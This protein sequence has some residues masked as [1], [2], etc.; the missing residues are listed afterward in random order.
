MITIAINQ[1]LGKRIKAIRKKLG[2]NQEEFGAM[3][4]PPAPKSVVSRWEHGGSPN[5]KRLAEIA[6]IGNVSVDFLVNGSNHL[7]LTDMKQ[8][9]DKAVT[10]NASKEEVQSLNEAWIDQDITIKE[11]IKKF[12]GY[13]NDEIEHELQIIADKKP[14]LLDQYTLSYL[15][16]MFNQVRLYG[17]K[18]QQMDFRTLIQLLMQFIVGDKPSNQQIDDWLSHTRDFLK[19]LPLKE[20]PN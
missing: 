12:S 1:G 8:L 11:V 4:T 17:S 14:G 20:L 19:S 5:K 2:K 18:K 16:G 10:G 15:L 6:D 9:S 7:T 3:F 13:A